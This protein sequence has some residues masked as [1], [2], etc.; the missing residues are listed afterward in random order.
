MGT[1]PRLQQ[2]KRDLDVLTPRSASTGTT[3]VDSTQM[4]M[5]QT[6]MTQT[7]MTQMGMTQTGMTQ[8]GST[9]TGSTQMG[10]I[11]KGADATGTGQQ[12]RGRTASDPRQIPMPGWKDIL[13]RSWHEVAENNI[14][15]VAGGVTY[16]VLLALFPAL[17]ALVAIYG[18]LL[19]PVQVERQVAAL[20][21]VLPPES[22][23]MIADEL[24]KLVSASQGSLSIGAG[25]AL[26]LALWSASRG[27]SGLVTAFNI[28]YEQK[29]TRGFFKLNLVAVGLTVLMLVG[30]TVIIALVGV[31]PAAIQFVGLGQSAQLLVLLLQWPL[32]IVVVMTGLAVLYRYAPDRRQPRWRWVSPGAVA[33]TVLWLAGSVAF[34]VYVAHFNSYDRTY[35]SLGGVVVMLTWLYL[36]SFV[37]LFGAVVN[38]QSERQT[39]ADSTEGA[40]RRMGDRRAHAADTVGEAA[41]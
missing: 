9:Q 16:A 33:A 3:N 21:H 28:A 11:Q 8:T 37:A 20:S 35:G 31:L 36:S 24:H 15:L 39:T 22:T 27:M 4:G 32:L 17:A 40:P 26:L 14:F 19:D 41:S 2:L 18:L 38:A 6:G 34:S 12:D 1:P 7:G 25:V 10:T 5:T 29:E 30:G 23:Q 13:L